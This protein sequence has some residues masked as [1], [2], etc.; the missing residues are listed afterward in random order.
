LIHYLIPIH[1]QEAFSDSGYKKGS[2]P[3]TEKIC[4]EIISLPLFP[5]MTEQEVRYAAEQVLSLVS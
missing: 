3:I 5:E 1:L 4:G 2:L